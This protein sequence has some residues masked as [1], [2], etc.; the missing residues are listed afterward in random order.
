MILVLVVI[1]FILH[2]RDLEDLDACDH[3]AVQGHLRIEELVRN[4]SECL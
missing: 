1:I 3:D 4:A 2:S